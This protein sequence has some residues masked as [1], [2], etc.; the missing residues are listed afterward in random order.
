MHAKG[1]T[2]ALMVLAWTQLWPGPLMAKPTRTVLRPASS[3]SI[4]AQPAQRSS[5]ERS[6]HSLAP[7]RSDGRP[8][9]HATSRNA[10]GPARHSAAHPTARNPASDREVAPLHPPLDRKRRPAGKGG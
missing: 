4:I 9:T 3:R 2:A 8:D 6:A 7:T 1:A 5:R 10:S